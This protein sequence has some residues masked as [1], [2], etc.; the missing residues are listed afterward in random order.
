MHSG[1]LD[2]VGTPRKRTLSRGMSEDESLR[3]LIKEA[4]G[5]ARRL[6][7]SDSRMG[8]VK[9]PDR[10]ENQTEEDLLENFPEMLDLQESYDE[11]VQE[12]RGL[13]LQ[14]EA[15]LFQVDC[16]QDA[17]EGAEEMLAEARRE[18]DDANMEL[19]R[20]RQAKRR[21]EEV[22]GAL[23]E[24]VQRL[25]EERTAIPLVPVYSLVTNITPE[26]EWHVAE[27]DV[28]KQE[29]PGEEEGR[30]EEKPEKASEASEEVEKMVTD[31]PLS[32]VRLDSTPTPQT[33]GPEE[34]TAGSILASFFRK[35]K[36]EQHSEGGL[37]PLQRATMGS[38]VDSESEDGAKEDVVVNNESPL[39]KFQRML[40]KT[41]SQ[42]GAPASP[43]QDGALG[44]QDNVSTETD[45][46][47][48]PADDTAMQSPSGGGTPT[49]TPGEPLQPPSSGDTLQDIPD[50]GPSPPQAPLDEEGQ[51]AESEAE[52]P[53]DQESGA[54]PGLLEG[55]PG[56]KNGSEPRSPKS[57]D[58]CVVS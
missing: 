15:L 20:E 44:H 24:E 4:E 52:A 49:D 13:E 2:K 23:T 33:L 7:R 12:L 28:G 30:T 18:A 11:V 54:D 5:S 8:S 55:L 31:A 47:P 1:S 53:G 35:G 17:L 19:E 38:S 40:N 43:Q 3:H 14:R 16:L 37:S 42:M 25:K 48:A 6:T 41:F 34:T 22:V 45:A 29:G 32:I 9:K 27:E 21:L 36:E 10:G 57:P 56:Q 26:E 58:S 39:A 51:A 46:P 50:V